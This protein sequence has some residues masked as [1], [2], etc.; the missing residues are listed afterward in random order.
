MLAAATILTFGL[1]GAALCA[2][3]KALTAAVPLPPRPLRTVPE[4]RELTP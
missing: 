1:L 2:P 3:L 4:L